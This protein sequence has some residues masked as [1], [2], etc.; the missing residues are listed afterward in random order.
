M[1]S[2]VVEPLITSNVLQ[3][4]T[5]DTHPRS[6]DT[7]SSVIEDL[8]ELTSNEE[9]MTSSSWNSILPE[10]PT[11]PSLQLS[12]QA[13]APV[14]RPL[15]QQFTTPVPQLSLQPILQSHSHHNNSLQQQ[16]LTCRNNQVL[17]CHSNCFSSQWY[18]HHNSLH[19]QHLTCHNNQMLLYRSNHHS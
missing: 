11:L 4:L 13:T 3:L 6:A 15:L 7:E 1:S 14:P 16:Y 19:F 17:R 10:Y 5:P 18:S 2:K 8:L 12:P 9:F